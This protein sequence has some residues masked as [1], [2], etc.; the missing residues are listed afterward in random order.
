[1]RIRWDAAAKW[2]ALAIVCLVGL[3][4]LSSLLRPPAPPPLPADVGLPH[5]QV[6]PNARPARL[7]SLSAGASS[8]SRTA[9]GRAG[10][11]KAA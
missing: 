11:G 4:A 7:G 9:E 8:S 5:V 6:K 3:H 1:M 10:D 2:A